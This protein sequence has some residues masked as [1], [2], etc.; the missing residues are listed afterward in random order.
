MIIVGAGALERSDGEAVLKAVN[1]IG[2]NSSVVNPSE[3]W[4]GVNILHN[5]IS[6]AGALD[7]GI[8]TNFNYTKEHSPKLL[9]LMGADNF[10]AED[11]PDDCFVIYQGHTG[12]EGAYYAD[13]IIPS[14]S[15]IEKQGS[16]VNMDGRVQQTRGAIASPGH[17]RDDW[18]ILRALSEEMGCP[19]P[20]DHMDELKS[21]IAEL[22]PHLV[23]YDHVESSGFE[24]LALA[25]NQ[26]SA[27]ALNGTT[28]QD[29]VDNF[30]M[31]DSISRTSSTMAK[32]TEDVNPKKLSNFRKTVYE[33]Y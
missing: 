17:A 21:R 11:I 9:W 10:R 16:F 1:K 18:M 24:G 33:M 15:Y 20:Y 23:K 12:D 22:A 14:S 19:L 32:C 4:N 25:Q 31:T 3:Y 26:R 8:S 29:Y 2:E 28:F 6:R 13:L 7:L 27:G 5:E 30:Y